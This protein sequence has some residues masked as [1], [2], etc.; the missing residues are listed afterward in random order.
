MNDM[1]QK[2]ITIHQKGDEETT[3]GWRNMKEREGEVNAT[4]EKMIKNKT[5]SN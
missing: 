1:S 4:S 5:W 2:E 3:S